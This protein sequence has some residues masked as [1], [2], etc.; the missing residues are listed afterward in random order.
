MT[1]EGLKT[2]AL[3]GNALWSDPDSSVRVVRE[4]LSAVSALRLTSDRTIDRAAQVLLERA[5][6]QGPSTSQEAFDQPFFRLPPR[7]RMLLMALHAG[8]WSYERIGH[9]MGTTADEVARAAWRTRIDLAAQVS[10]LR[11][12][13]PYPAGN[14]L[15]SVHCPEYDPYQPWTQLF[16]DEQMS[17]REMIYLQ[18]HLMACAECRKA[19][20]H[21]RNLYY[22]VESVIPITDPI[23]APINGQKTNIDAVVTALEADWRECQNE[24]H[25]SQ[26][27]F[28][29]SVAK[30]I[31]RRDVWMIWAGVILL[32][33]IYLWMKA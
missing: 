12:A 23:N 18:N 11:N 32:S 24:L 33:F 19:L 21:S 22:A 17:R 5:I 4:T 10:S 27:S 26:R 9:V 14:R 2:Y 1:P 8:G 20:A 25:P 6:R 29:E 16:L 31:R 15:K 28:L 3:L 30:F 13:I 7:E